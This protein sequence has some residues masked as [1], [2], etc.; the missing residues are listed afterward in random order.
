MIQIIFPEVQDIGELLMVLAVSSAGCEGRYFQSLIK[1][2][3][4][5][6][7]KSCFF[8]LGLNLHTRVGFKLSGVR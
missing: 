7:S 2:E 6:E 5:S 1:D 3:N 4:K 8:F